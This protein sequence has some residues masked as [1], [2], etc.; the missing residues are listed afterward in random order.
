[1]RD[2]TDRAL[3]L[4]GELGDACA[5]CGFGYLAGGLIPRAVH[6]RKCFDFAKAEIYVPAGSFNKLYRHVESN[7]GENRALE[8]YR[9]NENYESFSFRYVDTST[10]YIE[11]ARFGQYRYPGISVEVKPLLEGT[12]ALE[13]VY[14]GFRA[15]PAGKLAYAGRLLSKEAAERLCDA[16]KAAADEYAFENANGELAACSSD[17][18][19]SCV[20]Q[21]Y[22]GHPVSVPLAH[23][24]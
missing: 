18:I 5:E 12:E 22:L 23:I 13:G 24:G 2:Y 1:M 7:L 8:S 3:T 15:V 4:V 19:D 20:Q 9:D 14:E 17:A 10:T 11:L 6:E 16:G 21:V